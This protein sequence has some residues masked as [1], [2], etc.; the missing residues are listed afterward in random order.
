[1]SITSQK[2][3]G[4][5]VG[6]FIGDGYS[7]YNKKNRHYNVEFYFNSLRDVEIIE[8]VNNL[9]H[10]LGFNVCRQ[11]DKRF[12]CVKLKVSSKV[13]MEFILFKKN[14]L[15]VKS[16]RSNLNR[17]YKLGVI[18]GFIDAEGY[19]NNGEMQLTQKDK[20]VLIMIKELCKDLSITTRKFYSTKNYKTDNLIWRLRI[21]TKFKYMPH[22]SY[23]VK[24][25]Y[26]KIQLN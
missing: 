25:A 18:S 16:I 23:K 26:S 5:L 22:N 1:M 10:K 17:D 9:L 8:F 15:F 19:V 2:E 4:Y 3:L 13:F 7:N 24:R 21:S 20:T 14:E 11:K 12:N 6:F